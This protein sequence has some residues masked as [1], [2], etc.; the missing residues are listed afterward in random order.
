MMGEGEEGSHEVLHGWQEFVSK[1]VVI[2][3]HA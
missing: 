3:G 2:G 1:C